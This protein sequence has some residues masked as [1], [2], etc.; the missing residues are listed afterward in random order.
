MILSEQE[1]LILKA[2]QKEF[3][4]KGYD[5]AR[6]QAIA[7][8]AS[9]SKAS[10]HYHFRSKEKLFEKVFERALQDYLPII[11]TLSDNSIGWEEKIRQFTASL[12]DFIQHGRMLFIVREINRN[13]ELI[14]PYLKDKK[15][16]QP[17]IV[18]YFDQLQE[19][20]QINKMDSRLLYLFLNSL[21]CFP[22]INSGMFQKTLR[23]TTKEYHALMH[24]YAQ[25]VAHFFIQAIKKQDI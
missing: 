7:D 9:I 12:F 10:L 22:V 6:M 23:M 24:T 13:P 19:Q 15:K 2:A 17:H 16:K 1:E 3:E 20:G 21:C 4:A 5:G 8:A 11:N 14:T 18:A 25:S